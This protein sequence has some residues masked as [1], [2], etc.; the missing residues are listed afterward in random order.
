MRKKEDSLPIPTFHDVQKYYFHKDLKQSLT[1][2]I[3]H[4]Q[5]HIDCHEE[6]N[7]KNL[8]LLQWLR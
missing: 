6:R 7:L 3:F 8:L 1:D 5:R 2:V 4:I